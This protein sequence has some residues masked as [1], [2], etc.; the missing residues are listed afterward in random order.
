ML[1]AL[2]LAVTAAAAITS[3]AAAKEMSV[4]ISS[5]GPSPT[6]PGEP[7]RAEL[8]VHGEPDI[9]AE[10]T[11]GITIEGPGG[12]T[13]TF[14]AK[15]TGTQAPDGQLVY[16]VNVVFPSEGR[17]HYTLVDGVT[18]RAY[19]GGYVQVG[20]PAA[21]APTASPREPSPAAAATGEDDFP[22]WPL[23]SGLLVVGLIG[24][25]SILVLRRGGPSPTP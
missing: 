21:A 19:E 5:G 2:A 18:E 3:A 10:A 6:D 8:L 24:A 17:W 9:L 20:T 23:I 1:T 22:V 15:P 13:R 12:A 16:R 25:G 4:S 7:W 11:P 14:A